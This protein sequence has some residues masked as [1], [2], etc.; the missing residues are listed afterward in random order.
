MVCVISLKWFNVPFIAP[1]IDGCFTVADNCWH[2]CCGHHIGILC[3][4]FR[5]ILPHIFKSTFGNFCFQFYCVISAIPAC[6]CGIC[7]WKNFS[8]FKIFDYIFFFDFVTSCFLAVIFARYLATSKQILRRGFA[9]MA[10]SIKLV[11]TG[12]AFL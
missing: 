4:H 12:Q 10:N 5:I 2:F 7:F 8:I 9:D 3:K 1:I 11:C 6:R